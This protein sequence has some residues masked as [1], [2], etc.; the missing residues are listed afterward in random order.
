MNKEQWGTIC[1]CLLCRQ[2]NDPFL[3][4]VVTS[5]EKLDLYSNNKFT[6]QWLSQN[7]LATPTP[8]P[9]LSLKKMLLCVWWDCGCIIHFELQKRRETITA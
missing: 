5:D 7:Q 4:M 3:I 6:Y 8:K 9:S 1:T 2:R